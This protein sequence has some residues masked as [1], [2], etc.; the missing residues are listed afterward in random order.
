[1]ENGEYK[2]GVERRMGVVEGEVKAIRSDIAEIKDNHLVH[3]DEK[4]DK[5]IEKVDKVYWLLISTLVTALG[6]IA[7]RFIG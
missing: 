7:L 5:G 3:M 6:S 2:L 1:M 4:I